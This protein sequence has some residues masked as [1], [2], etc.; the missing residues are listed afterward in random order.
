MSELDV[1]QKM[2][3]ERT[4][5]LHRCQAQQAELSLHGMHNDPQ[6]LALLTDLFAGWG[7]WVQHGVFDEHLHEQVG[8]FQAN[9]GVHPAD[10]VV[11]SDTWAALAAALATEV[12]ELQHKVAAA[13]HGHHEQPANHPTWG[14]DDGT[15]H[16]QGPIVEHPAHPDAHLLHQY[17]SQ[18]N[19]LM[20]A[21]AGG[22]HVV[23]S[24]HGHNDPHWL[25][26]VVDCFRL[27]DDFN[28]FDTVNPGLGW[29]S[30][31][32]GHGEYG[33][34]LQNAVH[35]YQEVNGL[36]ATGDVDAPT[37]ARLSADLQEVVGHLQRRLAG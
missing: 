27:F 26:V 16:Y 2:L 30:A 23:L 4:E 24:A 17:V 8:Q 34:N 33:A 1:L 7:A 10:G 28:A 29:G 18:A 14:S 5:Y 9:H 15:G 6:A 22:S 35:R 32:M 12:G 3:H 11:R 25:S 13:G 31:G 19:H 21:C 36:H 20:H 37:W